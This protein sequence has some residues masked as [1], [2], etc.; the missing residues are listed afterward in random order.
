VRQAAQAR[1]CGLLLD[2]QSVFISN[3]SMDITP[4]V[5][6]AL[7]GKLTTFTIN[8]ERLPDQPAPAAAGAAARPATPAA[9]TPPATRR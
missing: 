3:P 7:N 6:T 1:G 2:Q 8:R 9:Q 5:V 4:Q